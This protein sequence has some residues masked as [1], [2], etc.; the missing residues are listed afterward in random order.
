MGTVRGTPGYFPMN[1]DLRDGS[2]LWDMW[3]FAAIILECDMEVN[4]YKQVMEER[5][6][7]MK[8]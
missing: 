1:E 3:A 5:E 2:V 4:E 8:A 7:L 6:S